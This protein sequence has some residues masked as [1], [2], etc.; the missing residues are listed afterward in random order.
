MKIIQPNG[1]ESEVTIDIQAVL[2]RVNVLVGK[3]YTDMFVDENGLLA[4]PAPRTSGLYRRDGGSF[5][6]SS[7]VLIDIWRYIA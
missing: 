1:E 7:V 4:N 3:N 6:P 5:L 2:A